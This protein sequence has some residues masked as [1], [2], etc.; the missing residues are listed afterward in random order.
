MLSGE[1][2]DSREGQGYYFFFQDRFGERDG[3][4]RVTACGGTRAE[5]ACVRGSRQA[6][7]H[8]GGGGHMTGMP[9]YG[10]VRWW[11]SHFGKI[12]IRLDVR[13]G[14]VIRGFQTDNETVRHERNAIRRMRVA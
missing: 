14:A 12:A 2:V 10:C 3:S 9:W 13:A 11:N 8:W 4:W 5:T 7:E 6:P 1:R